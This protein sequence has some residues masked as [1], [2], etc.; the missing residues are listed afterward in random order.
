MFPCA[1]RSLTVLLSKFCLSRELSSWPSPQLG[2]CG[3]IEEECRWY[4]ENDYDRACSSDDDCSGLGPPPDQ[5]V[6]EGRWLCVEACGN[7]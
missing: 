7:L 6:F 5:T 4:F 1:A 2:S 3:C